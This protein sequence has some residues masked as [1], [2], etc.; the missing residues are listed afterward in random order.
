[1]EPGDDGEH[2]LLDD[3]LP[4]SGHVEFAREREVFERL[5]QERHNGSVH[6]GAELVRRPRKHDDRAIRKFVGLRC[7][8]NEP[9]RGAAVV[10]KDLCTVRHERLIEH[11]RRYLLARM[12]HLPVFHDVE[13]GGSVLFQ[14]HAAAF[15]DVFLGHVVGGRAESAAGDDDVGAGEGE[16]QRGEDVFA[17]VRDL[18][19]GNR[20]DA[21][22]EQADADGG[23]VGIDDGALQKLVADADDGDL[24]AH[25]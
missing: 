2:A 12:A 13:R 8:D 25:K 24:F 4:Q 17:A 15:G 16:F 11:A 6:H 19:G 20:D 5:F 1:M 18:D 7:A 23:E 21:E 3:I 10:L 22:R 9:R 14:P